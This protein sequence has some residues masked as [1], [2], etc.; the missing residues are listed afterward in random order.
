MA[1]FRPRTCVGRAQH[2]RSSISAARALF[3]LRKEPPRS[4]F[5]SPKEAESLCGISSFDSP[6]E[7][8]LRAS[9]LRASPED[10]GRSSF[11]SLPLPLSVDE[12]LE[13]A[14]GWS[15]YQRRLMLWLGLGTA[16]CAVHM[17]QPIFLLPLID[18]DLTATERG[19][20]TTCF[21][22]GY[23]LGVLPW[24]HVSDRRGRRPT[25]IVALLIAQVGGVGSF[26]APSLGPFLVLR[27]VC[28]FGIAGAKNAL[29]L[30]ATEY[31]PPAARALVSAHISY[32]WVLGLFFLVAV[33]Y[34]LRGA[35]WR[36]LLLAHVPGLLFQAA[37]PSL[38]PE[39]LRFHLVDGDPERA[40]L[41]MRAVF[42]ANARPP[43][44]PLCLQQPPERAAGR[45]R[46]GQSSFCQL[47]APDARRAT[48]VVGLAQFVCTMVRE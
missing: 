1:E 40:H 28:G 47:W 30:L 34:G 27:C 21:F 20:M 11:D 16:T 36:W 2:M 9:P 18:W 24:A 45:R 15:A 35:H 25:I 3:M 37:L 5:D 22:A 33:A 13:L 6:K 7:A 10:F 8:V 44:E 31:A 26:L 17:L 32:A 46:N 23:A 12:A 39:S 43:P 19:L 14:G 4:S 48:L 41:A 29:F 42:R 38:L